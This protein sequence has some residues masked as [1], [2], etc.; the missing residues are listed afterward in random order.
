MLLNPGLT[1]LLLLTLSNLRLAKS[2]LLSPTVSEPYR[3]AN[4]L[5]AILEMDQTEAVLPKVFSIL[6]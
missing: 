2:F 3:P 4:E 6:I 1:L 5:G